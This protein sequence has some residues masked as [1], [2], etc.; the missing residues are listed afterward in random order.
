MQ[1]VAI[2]TNVASSNPV[3]GEV[4]SIQ[5]YLIKFVSD[6]RQVGGFLRALQS[7]AS[8]YRY[9]RVYLLHLAIFA[10]FFLPECK[11]GLKI[12]KE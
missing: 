9:T 10:L 6:L 2:T 7:T 12:P 4:Y 1:S 8:W 11:K 5:H 3:Q